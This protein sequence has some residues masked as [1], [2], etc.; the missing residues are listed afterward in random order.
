MNTVFGVYRRYSHSW[1]KPIG[2]DTGIQIYNCIAKK[3]VPFITRNK[4]FLTW[5]TCGPTVYDSSHIGHASCYVKLDI[6]QRILRRYY[7]LNLITVM[8][9]TDI[10]DKII[11]R[12]KELKQSPTEVSRKYEKEFLNDLKIL[13]IQMPDI[14]VRVTDKI[15]LIVRFIEKLLND[16]Y[17]YRS[18]DGSVY[19]DTSKLNC[20]GKLQ[21]ISK[22]SHEESF[23]KSSADFAL[24]KSAKPGEPYW[25]TKWGPGRPGWHIECSALASFFL[26][27]ELD[28]HAGGIDLQFPHHENEE[29]QSCAYFTKQ[30][31]VN[32]WI[33][34]GH[35][36]YGDAQKMSK[37]LKN[38]ITITEM[39]EICSSND[40][41]M[42]CLMSHYSKNMEFSTELI[43][44]AKGV[45]DHYKNFL[46]HC[47]AYT[48]CTLNVKLNQNVLKENLANVE[49]EIGCALSDDFDTARA[50][51]SLHNL[52]SNVNKMLTN[53]PPIPE[54]AMNSNVEILAC[55]NYVS[56]ILS[57]FGI[58]LN[59]KSH[60]TKQEN[61][62][63]DL[64]ETLINFRQ[65]VRSTALE[66]KDIAYLKFCDEVRNNLAQLG[67]VLKDYGKKTSVSK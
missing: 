19:F 24:W 61:N 35:L 3:K 21:N 56:N 7:N 32:Y 54:D 53:S 23:K 44:T 30:Q 6:I 64:L 39:L 31:W 60:T 41:R 18:N 33:H 22:D 15:D 5:Y 59:P 8:N 57:T 67:I 43:K 40:F 4:E 34:T 13:G 17:A 66:Q 36:H 45:I 25:E 10:D 55:A 9:V 38:T 63:E 51:K 16:G 26:G 12:S 28:V 29:A 20:Y 27:D 58:N 47:S 2:Q 42:A 46:S 37:S 65:S 62:F 48:D 11:R 50:L 14:M 52:T 1:I 49:K